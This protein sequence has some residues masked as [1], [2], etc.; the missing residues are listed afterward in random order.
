M[1]TR[2]LAYDLSNL[3]K[4]KWILSLNQMIVAHEG[5]TLFLLFEYSSSFFFSILK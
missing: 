5:M 1:P 2:R 4:N 3:Y